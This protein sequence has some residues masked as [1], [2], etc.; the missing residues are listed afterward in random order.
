[1]EKI[2]LNDWDLNQ[3]KENGFV[4]SGKYIVMSIKKYESL[5]TLPSK[6]TELTSNPIKT[7]PLNKGI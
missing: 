7:K 3:I 5:S 4:T 6:G 2:I 1:M